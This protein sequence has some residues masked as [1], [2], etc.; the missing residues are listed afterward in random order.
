ML[1]WFL[2]YIK[3]YQ[4]YGSLVSSVTCPVWLSATPWT[5]AHQAS[6]SITAPRA[7]SNSCP[8]SQWFHP[9]IST[10]VISFFSCLQSFP[11]SGSFPV[12]RCSSLHQVAQVVE[13]QLQHQAFQQTFRTD[14]LRTDWF[15]LL[16]CPRDSEESSPTP[17]FKSVNSSVLSFLYDPTLTSL[18]DHWKNCSFD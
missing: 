7:C 18:H 16:C 17:Q 13:L 10:S 2:L 8:L 5:A 4:L 11:A 6:L 14:F 12:K 3:V 1:H 9:T 15:D